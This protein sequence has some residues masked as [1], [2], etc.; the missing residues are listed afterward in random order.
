MWAVLKFDKKNLSN[1]KKDFSTKL[2]DEVK[3]YIP[4]IQLKKHSIKKTVISEKLILGDY[5]F[6]FHEKFSKKSILTSLQYSKGLKCILNDFSS[7]QNEIKRF[8]KKCKENEDQDGYINPSFFDLIN[9]KSYEFISGPF[10]N[11]ILN[12]INQNKISIRAFI[13]NYRITVSKKNNLFRP[14]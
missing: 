14:V 2:G 11:M 12:I 7:S 6:C 10:S 5:L 13:G 4:K 9:K 8:I 3:F 1:L